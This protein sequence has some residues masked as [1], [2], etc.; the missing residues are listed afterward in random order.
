MGDF[1]K[2]AAVFL[3]AAAIA[4]YFAFGWSSELREDAE[5]YGGGTE[6]IKWAQCERQIAK[7]APNPARAE[8]ICGCMHREFENRGLEVLDTF[9]PAY[10][11]MTEITR[12]CVELYGG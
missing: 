7:A 5:Q 11:E 4:G 10:D 9:G 8:E 2:L 6:G 1:M 3:I 12:S